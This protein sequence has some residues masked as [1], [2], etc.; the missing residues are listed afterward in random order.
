MKYLKNDELAKD[1]VMDIFEQL[2]TL[3][4]RHTITNFKSWLHSVAKNHCLMYLRK[5]KGIIEF[6]NLEKIEYQLME[7]EDELHLSIEKENELQLLENG[8]NN[9][10]VEQKKCIEL[11]YLNEKSYSEVVEITGYELKK[12]KSYLQNGKRNLKLYL[13]NNKTNTIIIILLNIV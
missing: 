10:T 3:L 9:L 1:A 13:M 8:V 6:N 11:F 2:P 5:K 7:N 12:V 4:Q